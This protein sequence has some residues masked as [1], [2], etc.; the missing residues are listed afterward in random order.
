[1]CRQQHGHAIVLERAHEV[2]IAIEISNI[3][4]GRRSR[5]SPQPAF[6]NTGPP[7][8]NTSVPV[9]PV[10]RTVLDVHDFDEPEEILARLGRIVEGHEH[11]NA[12]S[13][14]LAEL[15]GEDVLQ[16]CHVGHRRLAV[17]HATCLYHSSG[18]T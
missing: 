6:R 14:R 18:D 16:P 3:I 9:P 7:S 12:V 2:A 15:L 8:R 1:M 13:A 4:P 5:S 17:A 11:A 10:M